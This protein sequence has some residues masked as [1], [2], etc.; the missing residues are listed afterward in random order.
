MPPV[1]VPGTVR[2]EPFRTAII[3]LKSDSNS[4]NS[5]ISSPSKGSRVIQTA[6]ALGVALLI[7][8]IFVFVVPPG[9]APDEPAHVEYVDFLVAHHRLPPVEI[10]P[11]GL[12]YEFYQPPLPYLLMAVP[13]VLTNITGINYPFIRNPE[14]S[15]QR[16]QR[17]F[18]DP[19][20]SVSVVRGQ[21]TIRLA[22]AM[23]LF[24]MLMACAAIL[25][26]C[27][28]ISNSPMIAFGAGL[29]F[30][31]SPQLLFAGS[32]AGNDAAVIGLVA[33]ATMLAVK[34][35]RVPD[36]R[37]A[38]V[39]SALAG[40]ALWTKSSAIVLAPVIALILIWFILDRRWGTV[41]SLLSPGLLL[42]LSWVLFELSR[43]GTISPSL[44]TGWSGGAG[45]LRLFLEPKWVVSAW[46]GFWA[47]LG[48]FNVTLPWPYYLAF[49][50]STVLA[51][52][53]FFLILKRQ[54]RSRPA[55]VL[56]VTFVGIVFLLLLYMTQVD[57]QPQ[58]RYLLP[59]SAAIAG[60]ATLGL[61]TWCKNC[62]PG[63]G[64]RWALGMA[65]LSLAVSIKT[66]MVLSAIY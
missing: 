49:L 21:R 42:S 47:K 58:G 37:L 39:V 1:S 14:F 43:T 45:V 3:V 64:T 4:V 16:N 52:Y 62:R 20:P 46:G 19:D 30:V 5:T 2:V 33:L 31:I 60:L 59:G 27:Y 13:L 34:L 63:T 8:S 38:L 66:V 35:V 53:G 48:W 50:P 12:T 15:F 44:P 10:H 28:Q 54:T 23:N 7:S 24:W 11:Q 41:F 25:G 51:G 40:I 9:E 61:E 56:V 17:A 6:I 57:W 36:N 29:P 22:R 26:T 32:T 65:L 18:L 55:W